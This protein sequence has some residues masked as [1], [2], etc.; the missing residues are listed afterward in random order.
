MF[1]NPTVLAYDIAAR[2]ADAPRRHEAGLY[3]IARRRL[4]KLPRI[5]ALAARPATPVQP[6][7]HHA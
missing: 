1:T 6:R 2:R 4:F 5:V 7:P 3:T